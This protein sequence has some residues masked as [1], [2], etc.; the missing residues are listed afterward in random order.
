[1][2]KVLILLMI[3]LI[4]LQAALAETA[5]IPASDVLAE[6]AEPAPDPLEGIVYNYDE[7]TIGTV[8]PFQGGFFTSMWG[9]MTSDLDV[10]MLVHGYN[11]IHWDSAVSGFEVDPSVVSGI[12]VTEN[13]AGD[14]TYTLNIYNDLFY[15]DGTP[16]TA[17]DYVFSMLLNVSPEIA[18]IGGSVRDMDYI[19]GCADY[20]AGTV[21]YLAGVRL[22]ADDQLSITISNEYLPFFYE[23]GLLNCSPYPI[24]VIAPGCQVA[25]DGNGAYIANIDGQAA[26]IFTADLLRETILNEET[27]YLSHP[28]VSSGPYHMVSYDGTTVE[29]E[30][31]GYYKGNAAGQRPSIP[32]LIYT[33]VS[34]DTAIESFTAGEVGLLNKCLSQTVVQAGLQLNV[35][36]NRMAMSNYTRNG[37][38]FLSFACEREP[39]NSVAVRQA[40][41]MC[42]NKDGFVTDTVGANG[43][44]VDG[45]YG[46][47]QWMRQIVDGTLPYPVTQPAADAD[48]AALAAYDAEVSAWENLSLDNVHVYDFDVEGAARLLES[49]GWN[50]NRDGGAFTLG[51]DSVRCRQTANG[52]QA[53]ELTLVAPEGSTLNNGLQANLVEPLAQAGIL[54]DVKTVPMSELL[55]AYYRHSERTGDMFL[56]ATNF[57]VVFD[58]S[59]TF[60]PDNGSVNL[61]NPTAIDDA[62]LYADAVAMRQT[63]SGDTLAYC[64]KWVTFQERFAE[65]VPVIPIYSNVYFDFY[66]RVL[67]DYQINGNMTWSEAIVGATLSDVSDEEAALPGAGPEEAAEADEE[68]LIT[69]D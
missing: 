67:H 50:L 28:S 69:L 68:G 49:E 59:I 7:L 65:V 21:P 20:V 34:N 27:G 13:A 35:A 64:Q 32:K 19:L 63:E 37:M 60:R 39:V 23:M 29:L 11:L 6:A 62:Q 33:V 41:A 8:N 12:V 52:L 18:E 26:P 48:D 57:D 14:R 66:P 3:L 24:S 25:D 36:S 38:S 16:I 10:R 46:M 40:I 55:S 1:M 5:E 56:L 58:P 15:S 44:R 47:G 54:L 22:L 43:L 2:K 61:Y 30:L 4:G 9:N 51:T 42:L 17:R 53:L 31:N 45:Y